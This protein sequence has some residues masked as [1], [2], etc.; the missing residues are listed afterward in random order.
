MFCMGIF[1]SGPLS[2]AIE[3]LIRDTSDSEM[4]FSG[5]GNDASLVLKYAYLL[6]EGFTYFNE[7]FS[8]QLLN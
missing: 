4:H 6:Q 8:A 1:Q 5:M 7:S 3:A 2:L